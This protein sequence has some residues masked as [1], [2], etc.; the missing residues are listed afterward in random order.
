MEI[1][2][3]PA[4]FITKHFIEESKPYVLASVNIY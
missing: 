3:I 2:N 4:D 1:K